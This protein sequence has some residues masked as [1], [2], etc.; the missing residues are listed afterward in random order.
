MITMSGIIHGKTIELADATGLPDGEAVEVFVRP[1]SESVARKVRS[2]LPGPPPG[3]YPG[4]TETAGG[5]LADVWT[6]EDDRIL[7]EIEEDR[8]R[9]TAREIP[10]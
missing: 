10:E 6:E 5:M 1:A 9:A 8:Q 2:G 7:K 3:W 4:C